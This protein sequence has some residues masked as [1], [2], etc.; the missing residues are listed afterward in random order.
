M[1]GRSPGTYS[2][3]RLSDRFNPGILTYPDTDTMIII[4]V[5]NIQY[6]HGVF[7]TSITG[8]QKPEPK[9]KVDS[10]H[11]ARRSKLLEHILPSPTEPPDMPRM[12][13]GS[14]MRVPR[15]R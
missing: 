4:M 14:R 6:S 5:L 11:P 10:S 2:Y 9:I 15:L 7:V 12:S 3:P 1:P 8:H 13:T